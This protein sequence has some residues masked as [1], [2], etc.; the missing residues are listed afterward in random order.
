[1]PAALAGLA[2]VVLYAHFAATPGQ[3]AR[4]PWDAAA[5]LFYFANF[6]FMTS[7]HSYWEIF[8]RPSPLQ[9]YW[10]L[11]IEE[12]FYLVYPA[13]LIGIYV[14][15][16]RPRRALRAVLVVLML[17]STGLMVGLSVLGVAPA[18]LYYGTDTRASEFL[19]G[20][21]LSALLV[22]RGEIHPWRGSG[23]RVV[24]L[25]AVGWVAAVVMLVEQD[26]T[27]LYRGGFALYSIATLVLINAALQPSAVRT[28]LSLPPL[29]WLGA[30]SYGAYIYHWPIYL[31]LD[32]ERTGLRDTALLAVQMAVTLG[33]AAVSYRFFEQPIRAG[34]GLRGGLR[35]LRWLSSS[36]SRTA[37][38]R[39]RC[40]RTPSRRARCRGSGRRRRRDPSA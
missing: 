8:S 5:A 7:G 16:A 28:V 2:L 14:L 39:V 6:R 1:M 3:L 20:A 32:A 33:A 36:S 35:L 24:T 31:W 13:L 25:L 34:R 40:R 9:H 17:V 18:R 26:S 11:S 30:V 38:R 19:M 37:P 29:P 21:L 27:F 15:S 12:Q 10:S 4:L 22:R 23:F